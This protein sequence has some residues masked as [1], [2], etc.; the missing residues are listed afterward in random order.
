MKRIAVV[1]AGWMAH[2]RTRALLQTGKVEIC[3]I[4][5]RRLASAQK[6]GAE[7]GCAACF[8]DY[9]QLLTTQPDAVLVEVPHAEQ[10]AIV[11]W[12][13]QHSLHVFIGGT[14]ATTSEHA[15][16]I[17]Q[18]AHQQGLVVEAGYEARYSPVWEYARQLITNGDI[19]GLV[20]VRSIALWNGDPYT[21]YYHQQASGGMPL[22]HMT[23]CFINP[24]RWVAGEVRAVSAFTNRVK[25]IAPELVN[26]ENCVANLLLDNDVLY[27]LTAGFVAPRGLPAWSVT[28]IGTLGAVEVRPDEAGKG[29]AVAYLNGAVVEHDFRTQPSAFD[30]QASAFLSALDGKLTCLNTPSHTLGDVLTAE[31]V[32]T[33]AHEHRTMMLG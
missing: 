27:S 26:E 9:T 1:G 7:I 3:G 31:A 2:V 11:L 32:V 16:Q 25:N 5:T 33:S 17:A 4:A 29:I 21:W 30:F 20:T 12:A 18:L 10:D 13:L 19:G 22:T 15:R 6:F 28:I 23:Y 24:V 8:D 14:L